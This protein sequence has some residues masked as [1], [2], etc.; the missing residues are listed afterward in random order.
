MY[1]DLRNELAAEQ[2]PSPV[3]LLSMLLQDE[4]CTPECFSEFVRHESIRTLILNKYGISLDLD[5][6]KMPG[7][8]NVI[9]DKNQCLEVI[10][11]DAKSESP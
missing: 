3:Y 7:D 10:R 11:E 1:A 4:A 9:Y 2:E 8:A 5:F 6:V